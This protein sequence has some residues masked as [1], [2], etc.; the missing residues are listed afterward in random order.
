MATATEDEQEKHFQPHIDVRGTLGTQMPRNGSDVPTGVS[1]TLYVHIN[2]S[3]WQ[4]EVLSVFI[5]KCISVRGDQEHK[6]HGPFYF[7]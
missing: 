4:M 5:L 6:R 1:G 2:A 7:D 3:D